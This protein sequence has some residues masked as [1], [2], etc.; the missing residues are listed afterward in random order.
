MPQYREMPAPG[1]RS[2]Q[3][4]EQWERGEYK[5]FWERKLGKG[6]KFER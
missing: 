2:G 3:V 6:I 4:G 5:G 1:T